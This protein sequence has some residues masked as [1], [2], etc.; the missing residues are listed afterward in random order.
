[1]PP[2]I[3]SNEICS[4]KSGLDRLCYSVIIEI[5]EKSEIF[6]YQIKIIIHS[7]KRFTYQ[8]FQN[9]IDNKK[10]QFLEELLTK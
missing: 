9:I 4:L 10:G 1:M 5:N 2:E 8:D 6:S 7:N 3:L